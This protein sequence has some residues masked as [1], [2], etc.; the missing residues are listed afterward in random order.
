MATVDRDAIARA[1]RRREFEEALDEER[2]REA[3]L[4]DQIELV[5]AEEEGARIDREL[6]E[7]LEP[8]EAALLGDLLGASADGDEDDDPDWEDT[9]EGEDEV[10]RLLEEIERSR[11]RQRAL[12]RAA[13]L[14]ASQRDTPSEAHSA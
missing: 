10:A 2:G 8:G 7:L 11:E 14:V 13:D 1:R 6:L 3:A 4:R 9:A 12:E 5:V